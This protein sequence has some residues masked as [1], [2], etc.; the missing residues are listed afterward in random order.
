MREHIDALTGG[1]VAD[2]TG[3][4]AQHGLDADQLYAAARPGKERARIAALAGFVAHQ[5]ARARDAVTWTQRSLADAFNPEMLKNLLVAARNARDP[6]LTLSLNAEAEAALTRCSDADRAM[7]AS[8]I[9]HNYG[10][11]GLTAQAVRF[12]RLSLDLLD[13]LADAPAR[14]PVAPSPRP[15]FRF[16]APRRN[17]IA[18]SLFGDQPRYTYFALEN[19]QAVR[20]VYPGWVCRYYVDDSTPSDCV[21]QLRRLGAEIVEKPRHDP[22]RNTGLFWRFE[23]AADPDVDFFLVRDVDSVINVREKAA[24]DDWIFNSNAQF[25]LMRDY[26]SHT[27]LILAGM[28]G[29]VGGVLGDMVEE[30][31]AFHQDPKPRRLGQHNQDQ[32]FLGERVWPRIRRASLTHDDWF[33]FGGAPDR[34]DVRPFP[35]TGRIEPVRHVG[36]DM[37]I[38]LKPK[39]STA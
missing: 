33:G 18:F 16:D 34:G 9:G 14:R 26:Y 3:Y 39:P 2:P 17:V 37:S 12:G 22:R 4:F 29:G 24:V 5:N 32:V 7:V 15:S 38:F 35:H 27:A 28:W 6:D 21:A 31:A 8:V 30:I 13:A 11:L 19:A 23:V 36:Q 25:H 10:D 20:H 1:R